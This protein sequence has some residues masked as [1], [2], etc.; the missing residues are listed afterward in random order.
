MCRWSESV[1]ENVS[2]CVQFLGVEAQHF[3]FQRVADGICL[4]FGLAC[5]LV[6]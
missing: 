1:A 5:Q 3:F 4:G 6:I 2:A